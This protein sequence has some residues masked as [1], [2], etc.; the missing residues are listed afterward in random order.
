MAQ[1]IARAIDLYF[2]D[3]CG[4]APTLPT[5]YTWARVGV[6]VTVPY[7]APQGRRVNVIGALAPHGP[8]PRLVYHS[9]CGKIDSAAFIDFLWRDV[10]Q[11][12]AP[13]QELPPTYRRAA[14]RHCAGQLLRPPQCRR[15]GPPPGFA[16]RWRRHLLLA[17]VLART[18]RHRTSLAAHQARGAAGAQLR[19]GRGPQGGRRWR[20]QR[21]CRST[22]S[23]YDL[24]MRSCLV[25][26]DT[27]AWAH[28]RDQ[29]RGHHDRMGI[30]LFTRLVEGLARQGR[31]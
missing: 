25:E 23:I 30:A 4:F 18:Q 19:R 2:L 5:T 15:E 12:P 1:A 24:F 6:R 9:R 11:V 14:L 13:P 10:A 16:G 7:V 8:Q 31:H 26:P 28:G 21:P 3:E 27:R 20:A 17:A 22:R 29:S